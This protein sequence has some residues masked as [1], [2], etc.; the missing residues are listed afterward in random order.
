MRHE[1]PQIHLRE[2][3]EGTQCD[4]EADKTNNSLRLMV[5]LNLRPFYGI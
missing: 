3:S 4:E 5:K 2:A 1:L